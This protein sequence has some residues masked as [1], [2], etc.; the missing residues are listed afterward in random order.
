M[1]VMALLFLGLVAAAFAVSL[2]PDGRDVGERDP[3]GWW[4][5]TR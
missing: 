2:L 1:S 4:P 5:G 3:R